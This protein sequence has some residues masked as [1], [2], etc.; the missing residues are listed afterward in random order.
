MKIKKCIN[1]CHY[2]IHKNPNKLGCSRIPVDVS[3]EEIENFLKNKIIEM[4]VCGCPCCDRERHFFRAIQYILDD[5]KQ[6][7]SNL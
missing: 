2:D 1:D 6:I 5:Y 3:F 7:K 4:K